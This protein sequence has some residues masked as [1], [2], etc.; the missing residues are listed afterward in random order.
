MNTFL[1]AN[2]GTVSHGGLDTAPRGCAVQL[3]SMRAGPAGRPG[4]DSLRVNQELSS[5]SCVAASSGR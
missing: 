4:L 3:L 2:T 1:S 5:E